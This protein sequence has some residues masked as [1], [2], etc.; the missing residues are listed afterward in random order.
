M[1][2]LDEKQI[3]ENSLNND[4]NL[5]FNQFIKFN[6]IGLD[7]IKVDNFFHNLQ[8][9]IPIYMDETMIG[10]FGYSGSLKKQKQRLTDLI[11][12]NFI[13]YK[14]QLYYMY[15]NKDY[16]K[17]LE[18][19]M[20]VH[21]SPKNPEKII[22]INT[23]YPPVPT[24]RGTSTTKHTLIM[25]KLFKEM[26]MLCQ[27]EKGKQVRSF[28]INMLDVF[29][30]Y[31]EFQNNFT[32]KTKDCKID[33]LLLQLKDDRKKSDENERK[34]DEERKKADEERKKA[35]EERKKADERDTIQSEKINR[36][37]GY[38]IE[39]KT[40]LDKTKT[41][42]DEVLPQRVETN[43]LNNGRDHQVII[44]H[45]RDALENEY[46]LY[47]LRVQTRSIQNSI[48]KIKHKFGDNI[49][50]LYTINQPNS[51]AFWN[52]CKKKLNTHIQKDGKTNWFMLKNMT[53]RQ[54]KDNL[55]DLNKTRCKE[56]LNVV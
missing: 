56:L 55:N 45:D 26:L 11:E 15:D 12:T 17:Y 50:R 52:V 19:L 32:I 25:P 34:A 20:D 39:T 36:L 33:N 47:V 22:D 4:V 27:T 24:G 8:N 13:E 48:D 49:H 44:L 14:D 37:L 21:P 46:D 40:T 28:Y 31:I 35:D 30:L 29:N 42:L 43:E 6:E 38:S 9:N 23:I 18:N 53:L 7:E 10:Y 1:L 54:F 2:L 16:T 5:T 51:V 3:L 41:T